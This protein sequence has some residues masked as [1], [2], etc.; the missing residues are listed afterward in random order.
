MR[1]KA[2][3]LLI[4]LLGL[5]AL[6]V[7]AEPVELPLNHYQQGSEYFSPILGLCEDYP[8]GTFAEDIELDFALMAEYGITDLRI[9]IAWNDYE[10]A[11]GFT[12]WWLL[13]DIVALAEQ[14]GIKLYPYIAYAP[15]WATRASWMSPPED[16]QDWYDFVY[17]AV[18]RYKDYIHTWE[19]WNEG[20]N[21]EFWVGTWEEQLEL[22][23]VGA[24]AVK[25][26][27][28][29]AKTVF[30]GLTNKDPRHVETIF[31]SGVAD[32]IDVINVHYYNETWDATPAERIYDS[33]KEV[34]DVIRTYGGKQELWIAEIGYSDYVD[35]TGRVSYWVRTRAP[36]EKTRE[37][38]A[39]TF[40][41]SYGLI[42][43][44]EDVSNVLWYE[45]KDLRSSS[46]AIGDVNNYHLGALEQSLF[47]KHLWFA[48]AS[49]K[50]LFAAPYRSIDSEIVIDDSSARAPYVYAFRR[51][52]GDV[53]L[54]AWNRGLNVESIAVTLPG[55]FNAAV[56]HSVTGEK[57]LV[58]YA[59]TADGTIVE[60]ELRPENVQIIELFA[61]EVPAL[62]TLD[63]VVVTDMG[64]SQYEISVQ[65]RN[66]GSDTVRGATIELVANQGVE[67]MSFQSIIVDEIGA[68]QAID[69][70]WNVSTN[71]NAQAWVVTR[72]QSHGL[73]ATLVEF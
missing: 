69:M 40:V 46:A 56:Q 3:F 51:E 25:A 6:S 66:I 43:A 71:S 41:R 58:N 28:P 49:V 44:T 50:Q 18:D 31:T 61:Q 35:E 2:L 17:E 67:V 65:V 53:I 21:E 62:L 73:A 30:G 60:L 48:V 10:F 11:K 1:T 24:Q 55:E 7:G 15:T 27:D 34:A 20:D 45:V 63:N 4:V 47:P 37:F 5:S 22:V 33:V 8:R 19:L 16:M 70:K 23:K 68:G 32:Y 64:N 54:L 59:A 9:S 39:V 29:T 72:S 12:D 36:Y 13:D 42:A 57:T 14:Y 26:A 38:Q 52:N